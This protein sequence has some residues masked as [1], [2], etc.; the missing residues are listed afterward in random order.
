MRQQHSSCSVPQ[1]PQSAT[2]HHSPLLWDAIHDDWRNLCPY[3]SWSIFQLDSNRES[4]SF[5]SSVSPRL[6]SI[7]R[8]LTS[9]LCSRIYDRQGNWRQASG[10]ARR[11]GVHWQ[12]MEQI[13]S[14]THRQ[15]FSKIGRQDLL[16]GHIYMVSASRAGL[17]QH[18]LLPR[19]LQ[20]QTC[21]FQ[22]FS[23]I[24]R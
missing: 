6:S 19:I 7:H 20:W 4:R 10:D 23:H 8:T 12:F 3:S 2:T 22:Q 14:Q 1:V 13:L 9:M 21:R 15:C 11:C 16:G 5:H 17:R 24:K 18:F